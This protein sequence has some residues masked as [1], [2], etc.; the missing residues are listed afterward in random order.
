MFRQA[1]RDETKGMMLDETGANISES[2]A[3]EKAYLPMFSDDCRCTPS[4]FS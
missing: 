3:D 2:D 1:N 4:S